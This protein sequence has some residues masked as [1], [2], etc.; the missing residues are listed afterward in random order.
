MQKLKVFISSVQGEFAKERDLLYQHFLTDALL[1]SFFEPVTFENLSANCQAPNI[2]YI[3]KVK[4]SQLYLALLGQE[5]GKEDENGISATELEYIQAR[6]QH[7]DCVAFIK[8]KS[9]IER[10]EKEKTF[11]SKIQYEL[12]YKRF[13]TSE[14]L[15]AEVNSACVTLLKDKGLIQLTSFDESSHSTAQLSDLDKVK[16]DNFVGLAQAKRGFPIRQGSAIEKI[17]THLHLLNGDK[18]CNSALLA[19]AKDPQQFFPTA[20]TKCAHFHGYRVEKPIPDHKVFQGD[21][22]QQVDQAID[23]VLLKKRV[24]VGMRD[25]SNQAPIQYEIPRAVIAESIVNAVAHRLYT[26]NGSVQVM[27]FV[28]RLEITN[29]GHLTPE[30]SIEKLKQEDT[31]YPT[32]PRLAEPMYQAGYI[33]RFG[34]GTEEMF[35]LTK[36]AGLSE[37]EFDLEEGFKVTIRRPGFVTGGVTEQVT[38]QVAEEIKRVLIVFYE[39]MKSAD[40]QI[41][42]QLKHREYFRANY[43]KP[44]IDQGFIERTKKE[45]PNSPLQKYR[46]TQKGIVFKKEIMSFLYSS[47]QTEIPI[48]YLASEQVSEQVSEQ[49]TDHDTDY[50]ANNDTDFVADY[51]V[52]Y[53]TDQDTIHDTDYDDFISKL[54]IAIQEEKSRP[55]LMELLGLNHI[56]N[57]RNNYLNPAMKAGLIE[58]T[59]PDSLKSK[60]QK[61]RLTSKG[62]ELKVKT[63]KNRNSG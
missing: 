16:I 3:E 46:L 58:M 15:I 13:E 53:D 7:I 37:P 39:D 20:V 49:A 40:I 32:N 26:S 11:I 4:Q 34:T 59:L 14:Q 61:Y 42:L 12:S 35:R 55:E 8:G 51:D 38:E 21:V 29:P 60:N 63:E 1:S 9:S 24:S 30:L 10:H 2:V 62:N 50:K 5:Y 41:A 18:L 52:I 25:T 57:F 31:S 33:E 48:C 6:V 23:F 56:G 47:K 19:F 45:K 22:F 28:D 36:E 43:L 17:L 44:S 27:L 54:I